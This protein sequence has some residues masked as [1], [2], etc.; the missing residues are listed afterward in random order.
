MRLKK[1]TL[2][3]L[4]AEGINYNDETYFNSFCKSACQVPPNVLPG[5]FF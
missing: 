1:D 4:V 2:S 3:T 5:Q